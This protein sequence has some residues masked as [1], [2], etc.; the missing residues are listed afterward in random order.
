MK[1]LS[2]KINTKIIELTIKKWTCKRIGCN[3]IDVEHYQ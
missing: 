1:Y 2:K 3:T